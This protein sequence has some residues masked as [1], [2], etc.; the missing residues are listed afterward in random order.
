MNQILKL[1]EKSYGSKDG[2]KYIRM[3]I[4]SDHMEKFI[5]C[6]LCRKG[7]FSKKIFDF[8]YKTHF[9]PSRGEVYRQQRKEKIK[10]KFKCDLCEFSTSSATMLKYHVQ[11]KHETLKYKCYD[12]EYQSI[13]ESNLYKHRRLKHRNV[14]SYTCTQCDYVCHRGDYLKRHISSIHD[15]V[16]YPRDQCEYQA[17]RK[18]Y[19]DNHIK[20][21]HKQ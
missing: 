12:C 14:R 7:F 16:R 8:H 5:S 19:L 9:H 1:C 20:R 3:H 11:R 21:I 18:Q 2:P 6:R 17:T 13:S 4:D 15:E 10:D